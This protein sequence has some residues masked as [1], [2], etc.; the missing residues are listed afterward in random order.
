MIDFSRILP[1]FV[2][3]EKNLRDVE[4][5]LRFGALGIFLGPKSRHRTS[6]SV[7]GYQGV[8]QLTPGKDTGKMIHPYLTPTLAYLGKTIQFEWVETTTTVLEGSSN[9]I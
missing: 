3:W 2:R 9:P 8:I 7:F 4:H 6:V 1:W 5:F